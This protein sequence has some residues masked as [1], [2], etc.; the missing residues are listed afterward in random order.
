MP[1]RKNNANEAM[2]YCVT[3]PIVSRFGE[4][5]YSSTQRFLQSGDF[6]GPVGSSP[7]T[8]L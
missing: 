7:D 1:Y 8:L 6:M 3:H 5:I 2:P 4:I